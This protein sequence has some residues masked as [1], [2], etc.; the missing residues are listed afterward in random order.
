MVQDDGTKPVS[1]MYLLKL[2]ESIELFMVWIV[3]LG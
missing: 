1:F 2:S 3:D